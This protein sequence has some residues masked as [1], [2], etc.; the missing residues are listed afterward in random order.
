[1]RGH[2]FIRKVTDLGH[3]R[4]VPVRF[5]YQRG[6]GSHGTLYYGNCKTVVKDRRKEIGPGLLSRMIAQL[7]LRRTDFR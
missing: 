6:K 7:G 1:M 5:E 4:N 2:E 3:E